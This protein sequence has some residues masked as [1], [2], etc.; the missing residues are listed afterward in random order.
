MRSTHLA[1]LFYAWD[2][3]PFYVV[4]VLVFLI[5]LSSFFLLS[6][7]FQIRILYS[8]FITILLFFFFSLMFYLYFHRDP[9]RMILN[10]E[11]SILSPADGK[12]VYIKK[13]NN[14]E[15]IETI[16]K[17]NHAR[18]TEL[19]DLKDKDISIASGYLI[20]IELRIFDVHITRSPISGTK[21]LDHHTS[22]RIVSMGNPDFE[23][24]NDRETL[25]LKK[26]I[27][28]NQ[29]SSALHIAVV[30]I[31]T[32]ITRTVKS[33]VRDKT[34]IKQG[35]KLGM[36]CLG[37]QVDIAIFSTDVNIIVKEHDRVYAGV[38]KI[39]EIAY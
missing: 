23:Y 34:L 18:L 12:I 14:G 36:I 29:G 8:I 35:E 38:T 31:A 20:G 30:Q 27:D 37:S 2:I 11:N 13:I 17:K 24:I 33:L 10:D 9:Q 32:F 28:L 19:L 7:L 26:E 16:K 25:L 6:F 1:D 5:P 3:N 15:I 21:I 22:G 4:A 39:A